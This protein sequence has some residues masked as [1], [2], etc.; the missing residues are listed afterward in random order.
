M[1]NIR[2][3]V[4]VDERRVAV[5]SDLAD[6]D[7]HVEWMRDATA[8]R[9]PSTAEFGVGTTFEAD[10]VV[11]PIHLVDQMEITEWRPGEAI[12]VR[13]VGVVIGDGR[14]T[15]EELPSNR[16]RLVWHERLRFPWWL[17]GAIGE[18]IA[19]PMLRALMRGNLRR[20]AA[21]HA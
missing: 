14:F 6:I 4:T 16:T 19:A 18:R 20:F 10:T 21:R 1:V 3:S 17:G 13:H 7:S 9:S 15:L 5:W 11:G 8:I 2:T 12:G